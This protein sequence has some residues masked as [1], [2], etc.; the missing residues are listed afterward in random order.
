MAATMAR[1][2]KLNY[3]EN[4]SGYIFIILF[5]QTTKRLMEHEAVEP[6]SGS[7][8]ACNNLNFC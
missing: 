5:L 7:S 4:T 2:L 8:S 1:S 3:Y 6:R